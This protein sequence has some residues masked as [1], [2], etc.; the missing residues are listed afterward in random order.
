MKSS[1]IK[2]L[3]IVFCALFVSAAVFAAP[4]SVAEKKLVQ[5]LE[6]NK[7]DGAEFTSEI[8]LNG[9]KVSAN[10][11]ITLSIFSGSAVKLTAGVD[12]TGLTE[13]IAYKKQ[14]A[15]SVTFEAKD[16]KN[17]LYAITSIDG[18][19]SVAEHKARKE[20]ERVAAEKKAEEE[21]IAAEK[22]AEEERLAK[23]TR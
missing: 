6:K 14:N 22:R 8:S 20:R 1:S 3:C 21:R 12:T 10:G 17:K 4:K 9:L 15:Y 11:E 13:R 18:I 5:T 16:A 19:E 23:L 2:K 7:K